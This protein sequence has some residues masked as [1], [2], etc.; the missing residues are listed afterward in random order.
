MNDMSFTVH[1]DATLRTAMK[2]IDESGEGVTHVLDDDAKL[3]GILT[4]G[5]VRRALLKGASMDDSV[6]PWMAR[7]YISVGIDAGRAEVLDLMQAHLMRHVPVVDDEGTLCGI[8]FLHNVIGAQKRNNWAVIMAGGKGTRLYP[9]TKNMPKP[10]V[11]VAGR[12]I[13]ERLILHL[14]GFGIRRIFISINYMGHVIQKHFGDG[15]RFGCSI[16]Y[17]EEDEPLGT[18]GALSLL[19]VKPADPLI[20]MNGDLVLQANLEQMLSFHNRGGYYAT[21]GAHKYSHQV[22]YGCI[23]VENDCVCALEEKPVASY[24][25]NAGLYVLSPEA[26]A[27]IPKEYFPITGLFEEAIAKERSCGSFL[28][29]DDWADV[30]QVAD[31]KKAQGYS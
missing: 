9:I 12:P 27:S 3:L 30:G 1:A 7:D 21:I 17:L 6:D 8:H 14:V 23:K 31:L 18:G 22:P 4:D 29:H 11:K 26:V 10:M 16:E 13:L 5:D 19:P 15:E 24:L 20:V 2:A 25:V 28:I